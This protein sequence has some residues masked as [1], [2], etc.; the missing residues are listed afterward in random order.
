MFK[1]NTMDAALQLLKT[2]VT[3]TQSCELDE[4]RARYRHLT[5]RPQIEAAGNYWFYVEGS[6]QWLSLQHDS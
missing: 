6:D 5:M 1:G 3:E 2:D 4:A